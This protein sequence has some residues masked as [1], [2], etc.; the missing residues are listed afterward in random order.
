MKFKIMMIPESKL[1]IVKSG[2]TIGIIIGILDSVIHISNFESYKV[3]NIFLFILF[4]ASVYWS[5]IYLR[6]KISDKIISYGTSFR[7][8]LLTGSIAA[9]F[10]SIIRFLF[11]KFAINVD[12]S[13][14]LSQTKDTM[15]S[16]PELY[17]EAE[18]NNNL[19]FIEFSYNPI[20]SSILYFTYYLTF[21]IIFAIIASFFIKRIDR[22][23][24]LVN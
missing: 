7:Q 13:S 3:L 18:I 21:V 19:S 20:I 15:L 17:T 2:V 14:I 10:I 9:F 8:I 23:I 22:N 11:L 5:V 6:D 4:F 1:F 12:L 16:N 24:S